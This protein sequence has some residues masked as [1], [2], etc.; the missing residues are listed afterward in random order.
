MQILQL[1]FSGDDVDDCI[2]DDYGC[3][4]GLEE[5][6]LRGFAFGVEDCV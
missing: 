3:H 1:W 5:E 2:E 4:G 6:C